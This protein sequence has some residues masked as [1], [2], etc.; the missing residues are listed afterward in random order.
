MRIY[1]HFKYVNE[2]NTKLKF[3]M[4]LVKLNLNKHNLEMVSELIYETD[5]NRTPAIKKLKKLIIAGKN[6]YGHEHVY[7]GEDNKGKI[8]G[9]LVAFKGDEI[10]CFEETKLTGM[11]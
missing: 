8:M 7:I 3:K 10:K 6:S 1:I 9:I 11:Q 4:N 5:K 2:L